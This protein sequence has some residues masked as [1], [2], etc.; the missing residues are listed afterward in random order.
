MIYFIIAI[1]LL[2]LSYHY[3]F[4]SNEKNKRKWYIGILIVLILLSGLRYRLGVDT[5]RYCYNFYHGIPYLWQLTWD[6]FAFGRDPLYML[7]NSLVL[8][9]GGKFYVVQLIHAAFVNGL[10]FKYI[11][12]HSSY[13]FTCVFFYFIWKFFAYNMEE[14]RASISVV[15]CLFANDYILEKKWIRGIFLYIIGCFFHAS[16]VIIILMIPLLFIFKLNKKGIVILVGAFVVGRILMTLLE[17]NLALLAFSD[18]ISTKAEGYLNHDELSGQQGNVFYFIIN[19]VPFLLY[20]ILSILYVKIK[21]KD[22]AMIEMEPLVMI[23]MAFLVIQMSIYMFYRFVNFYAIYVILY[24]SYYLVDIS[25]NNAK[26][27]SGVKFIVSLGVGSYLMLA[28]IYPYF[29][30]PSFGRRFYP[31]SSV[32]EKSINRERELIYSEMDGERMHP[33][34][35]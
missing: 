26:I 32:I 34:E 33:N 19:I 14:M 12:K 8:S 31:Y 13:I 7:F 2:L 22:V 6:D 5:T 35:Y 27:S 29:R 11:Q 20:S 16:T 28:M 18:V 3:D 15:I 25:K 30:E 23:A 24:S 4:C 1:V 17:E 9:L 21:K 10:L